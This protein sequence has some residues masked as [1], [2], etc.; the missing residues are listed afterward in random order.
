M[1]MKLLFVMMI[2]GSLMATFE[3]NRDIIGGKRSLIIYAD[4]VSK[5]LLNAKMPVLNSWRPRFFEIRNLCKIVACDYAY[6]SE[7]NF[8]NRYQTNRC[9]IENDEPCKTQTERNTLFKLEEIIH[10]SDFS[11]YI[12]LDGETF[13]IIANSKTE[14]A[15]IFEV[16]DENVTPHNQHESES[17][18]HSAEDMEI[19]KKD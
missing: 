13:G 8:P 6:L 14:D 18:E 16:G 10:E 15:L 9:Y 2:F 3:H 5:E 11:T 1:K 12:V 7:T 19:K 4:G 17:G